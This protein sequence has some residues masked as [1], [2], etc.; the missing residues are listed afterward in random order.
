MRRF[1]SGDAKRI[2]RPSVIEL[3]RL[4]ATDVGRVVVYASRRDALPGRLVAW[5]GKYAFAE[6]A[7]ASWSDY[8]RYSLYLCTAVF[9]EHLSFDRSPDSSRQPSRR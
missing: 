2:K 8:P 3:S 1:L 9:P 4:V 7:T 6:F 5:N